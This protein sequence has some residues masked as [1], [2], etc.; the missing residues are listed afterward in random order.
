MLSQVFGPATWSLLGRGARMTVLLSAV[1][2]VVGVIFGILGGIIR[3]YP[4]K[5]CIILRPIVWL[6]VEIFRRTP[7]LILMLLSYFGLAY[8]GMIVPPLVVGIVAVCLYSTAYMTENF[9]SGIQAIP[10]TQWD[11]GLSLGMSGRQLLIYVILP[12][13]FRISI[14]PSI[15]FI[16]S[17]VKDTSV[18]TIIG[19]VELTHVSMLLRYR[20]T[21]ASFYI[22]VAVLLIYF[23]ICYP[24]SWLGD[25]AERRFKR[26]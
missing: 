14:P 12:Q 11:G 6:W 8:T 25:R 1:G 19:L 22:F 3:S 9:R 16:Q 17:L 7:L 4:S 13:A 18:A 24:L 26:A 23:A 2:I 20:Y 21:A 10:R 15:G 5:S